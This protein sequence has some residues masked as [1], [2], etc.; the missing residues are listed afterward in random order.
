MKCEKVQGQLP[1]YQAE[2]LGWLARRRLAAHLRQCEGCRR[3]LRA[4][5]RTVALLHHAGSTAPVPDVTAAVMER[6]RREPV[7]AYRPRRTR[8]LVLV[9]AALAVLVTLVAQ[10][11][12]RDP[13][14]STPVDA[15]GAAYLEEYAQ[16]RA[17]QEIGDSTGILLLAS[18]LVDEPN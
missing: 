11:S 15:I 5:E 6:V 10:F 4:L 9:P 2:A 18:E 17:T 7:P 8:V 14:G 13:W 12:L 1:A 3:E 16:F